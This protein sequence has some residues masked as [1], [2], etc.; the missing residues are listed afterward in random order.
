MRSS[1]IGVILAALLLAGLFALA[2]YLPPSGLS[3]R[4]A[5]VAAKVEPGFTGMKQIGPWILSCRP[6]QKKSAPMPLTLT[7]SAAQSPVS[8][9]NTFGRCRVSLIYH[10]KGNPKQAVLVLN[11]RLLGP[12]QHLA[13]LVILPPVVKKGDELEL[14]WGKKGLKLPISVCQKGDCIAVIG[15]AARGEAD[16]L[17]APSAMLVLPPGPDGKR[18]GVGVPFVGLPDAIRAMRRAET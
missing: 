6:G 18:A 9:D 15:L 11:F 16:L 10:R 13:V 14:R 7:P 12:A 1:I 2:K 17:S 5:D 4:P 3:Q 8:A